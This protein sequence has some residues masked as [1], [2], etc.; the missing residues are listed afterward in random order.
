MFEPQQLAT[1]EDFYP[2]VELTKPNWRSYGLGWFQQD[3]QGRKIDF[4]TGSLSGLIA[5]IGLDRA[6]GKAI[7]VLGNRDHAEMRHALLWHVMDAGDGSEKRDWNQDIYDLYETAR[8]EAHV[9]RDKLRKSRIR[10]TRPSLSLDDY[11]GSFGSDIVGEFSIRRDKR[12]LILDSANVSFEL[13]HW[14]LDMFVIER[15]EWDFQAFATFGI[16]S[17]GVVDKL[18]VFG[19]DFTRVPDKTAEED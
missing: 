3:F 1:P 4:H 13:S 17:D 14:H 7:I 5:I 6:A 10:G 2:T 15:E 12:K 11:A 9:E 8:E 18:N 16:G 19:M